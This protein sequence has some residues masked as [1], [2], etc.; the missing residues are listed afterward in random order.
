MEKS[1]ACPKCRQPAFHPPLSGPSN[2]NNGNIGGNGPVARALR[3][4]VA[5]VLHG[6]AGGA[7]QEAGGRPPVGGAAAAAAPGPLDA[8]AV[9]ELCIWLLSNLSGIAMVGNLFYGLIDM[10]W[11][12]LHVLTYYFYNSN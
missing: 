10:C 12:D 5:G 2:A 8:A 9:D 11:M 4:L 3:G 1:E 7:G 6:I